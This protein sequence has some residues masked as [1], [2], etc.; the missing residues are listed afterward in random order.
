MRWSSCELSMFA[1]RRIGKLHDIVYV[2]GMIT[3]LALIASF[4]FLMIGNPAFLILQQSS[5]PVSSESS[6]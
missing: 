3:A 2:I 1:D 6:P 5:F 4:A